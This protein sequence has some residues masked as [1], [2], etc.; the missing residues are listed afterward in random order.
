MLWKKRIFYY[1]IPLLALAIFVFPINNKVS[2][3]KASTLLH[4]HHQRKQ[5]WKK[6]M[7]RVLPCRCCKQQSVCALQCIHVY[8][9]FSKVTWKLDSHTDNNISWNVCGAY[10]CRDP[11]FIW[12]RRNLLALIMRRISNG[13]SQIWLA[14]SRWATVEE[15]H[16]SLFYMSHREAVVSPFLGVS[17]A[18]DLHKDRSAFYIMILEHCIVFFPLTVLHKLVVACSI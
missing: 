16:T 11:D 10:S 1:T 8:L 5:K 4:K 15:L 14:P 3:Y 7:S 17:S 12:S 13:I 2:T 18:P 9:L 6:A